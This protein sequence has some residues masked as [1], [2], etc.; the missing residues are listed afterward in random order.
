MNGRCHLHVCTAEGAIALFNLFSTAKS[1]KKKKNAEQQ[2]V[3]AEVGA[4]E[5]VKNIRLE[6]LWAGNRRGMSQVQEVG[7]GDRGLALTCPSRRWSAVASPRPCPAAGDPTSW[8]RSTGRAGRSCWRA[9]SPP[10]KP[11]PPSFRCC[12]GPPWHGLPWQG[13]ILQEPDRWVQ[14]SQRQPARESCGEKHHFL[15]EVCPPWIYMFR[16]WL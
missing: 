14:F 4:V 16:L 9:A 6:W 15:L 5:P 10:S 11:S 3:K 7:L 1:A 12:L 8:R 2:L 13:V